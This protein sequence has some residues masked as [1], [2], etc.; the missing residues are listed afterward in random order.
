MELVSNTGNLNKIAVL[1]HL[2]PDTN[3]KLLTIAFDLNLLHL[4]LK[5]SI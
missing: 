1:R 4:M 2:N 3:I 5:A